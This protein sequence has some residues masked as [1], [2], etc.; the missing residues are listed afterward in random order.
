MKRKTLIL[1]L[2]LEAA[3]IAGLVY[4]SRQYPAWFTSVWSIPMEQIAG[5][6]KALSGTGAF[7]N[8]LALAILAGIALIPV[9]FALRY[10][11]GRETLA[12]RITL[13]VM[14]PVVLIVLW[15]MIHPGN[16]RPEAAGADA[17]LQV[18][19]AA[20]SLIIWSVVILFIVLRLIRLFRA[21]KREQLLRYF[22]ILLA[23]SCMAFTA[24]LAV[25][26]MN[27]IP[28]PATDG[29]Q[30]T[31]DII[32]GL[33]LMFESE[34]Q[35]GDVID[36]GGKIGI[37]RE[38]GLHSTKLIDMNNNVLIISNSKLADIINRTQRTSFA[39][40]DFTVSSEVKIRDLEALFK[41]KLPPLKKKYP[42]LIGAPYFR[43]VS[44]F[45]GAT[46]KC[47]IAAEV[48]EKD[49][50]PMERNLNKE[51][52]RILQDASISPM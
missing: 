39:F 20:L 4:L 23:V 16:V 44:T 8:G 37:V 27:A 2:I 33:F 25:T 45:S 34:F 10:P 51:V 32:A 19:R 46:M 40:V 52:L 11:R 38:I 29:S 47:G 15:N 43:G 12:E 13:A 1:I 41:E 5:G 28:A 22:R 50:I 31:Q 26:L 30:S 17:F 6:L 42:K 24:E 48:M 36:T 3:L 21:G 35:V 9:I 49:R 18:V 14:A 7:G